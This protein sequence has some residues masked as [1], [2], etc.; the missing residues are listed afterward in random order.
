M[1]ENIYSTSSTLTTVAYS[2]ILIFAIT[3]AIIMAYGVKYH[4]LRVQFK[5]DQDGFKTSYD[6]N[7]IP[8]SA[9]P[10]ISDVRL[11]RSMVKEEL[12]RNTEDYGSLHSN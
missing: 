1:K 2:L 8:V 9:K 3:C 6:N 7:A 12:P 10:S 11:M 4:R 5:R